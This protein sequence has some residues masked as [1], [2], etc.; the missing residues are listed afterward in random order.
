M[1][2]REALATVVEGK[3]LTEQE[4]ADAMRDIA[5]GAAT[6]A[7]IGAFAV[8]LRMKGE[9][10]DELAGFGTAAGRL[11]LQILKH[12]FGLAAHFRVLAVLHERFEQGDSTRIIAGGHGMG[13]LLMVGD[14]DQIAQTLAHLHQAGLRGIGFSFVNY[15]KELPYF[16]DEVLPRLERMGIREKRR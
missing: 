14:P 3:D 1:G 9:T 11:L 4:A 15:L 10:I 13:G 8:A 5:T 6:P 12:L 16:C 7:Q 2:M